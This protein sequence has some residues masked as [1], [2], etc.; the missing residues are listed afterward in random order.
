MLYTHIGVGK[1]SA[2]GHALRI[3]GPVISFC[4]TVMA[5]RCCGSLARIGGKNQNGVLVVLL[6][7]QS[8]DPSYFCGAQAQ[9]FAWCMESIIRC[10]ILLSVKSITRYSILLSTRG[11]AGL[12][13]YGRVA[14]ALEWPTRAE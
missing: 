7:S 10:L 2:H 8:P 4:C 14:L 3:G 5:S 6:Q 11:A 1:T 12:L 9:E 13:C